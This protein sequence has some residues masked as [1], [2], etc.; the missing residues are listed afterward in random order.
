MAAAGI[1]ARRRGGVVMAAAFL[2]LLASANEP[3]SWFQSWRGW[4]IILRSH[5]S[6]LGFSVTVCGSAV[7]NGAGRG[8][9]IARL[10]SPGAGFLCGL[11][12]LTASRLCVLTA[13]RGGGSPARF[14]RPHLRCSSLLAS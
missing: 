14:L 3:G 4:M 13:V 2:T 9:V 1:A 8:D 11:L 7:A 6:R 5:F 12:R 10:V